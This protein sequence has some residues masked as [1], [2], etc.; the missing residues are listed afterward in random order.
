VG[1]TAKQTLQLSNS[2]ETAISLKSL[3]ISNAQF[4]VAGP[5]LPLSIAPSA[6]VSYTVSFTPSAAGNAS[7]TLD[8]VSSA[9][10]KAAAVSL[11]GAGEKA[12]AQ[13]AITPAAISFGNQTL[14]STK[15]QNV[16]LQNTGDVSMTIQGVTVAGGGFGYSDLSPGFSLAPN[17]QV[18]FQVWFTPTAAGPSSATVSF[19][20]PSL[21]S[22]GTLSLTG[23]GVTNS[24]SSPAPP[25]P[26]AASVKLSWSPSSS[27]VIGY[28]VYRSD[29]SGGSYSALF[30]TALNQTSYT[31]S[32]VSSGTTYYY[33]V[34]A[35]NS[36]GTQS[37]YSNQVTAVVP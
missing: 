33:V 21:T 10:S 9:S 20:S 29:S 32:T 4:S 15:T 23:D 13:L 8:I 34:T 18:T 14:K 26:A 11:A 1:Q 16:T 19:L 6:T 24:S 25:T 17:Q 27:T 22:P 7:A 5:S 12:F 3:S 35:V 31:D 30:G 37:T 2:G 36:T 28:L